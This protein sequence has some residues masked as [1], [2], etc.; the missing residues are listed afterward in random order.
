MYYQL[1]FHTFGGIY[2]PDELKF[3]RYE[4]KITRSKRKLAE[5]ICGVQLTNKAL[6]LMN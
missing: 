4:L 5:N 3:K 1:H 2:C 6:E